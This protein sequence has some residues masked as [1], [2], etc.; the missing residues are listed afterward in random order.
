MAALI[1][2]K[3]NKVENKNLWFKGMI[4]LRAMWNGEFELLDRSKSF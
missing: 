2:E 1:A 3:I 4:C